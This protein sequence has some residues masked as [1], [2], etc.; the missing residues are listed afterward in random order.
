MDDRSVIIGSEV[1][2]DPSLVLR[3]YPLPTS[4]KSDPYTTLQLITE[5]IAPDS[6]AAVGG[7]G[8]IMAEKHWGGLIV[9]QSPDVQGAIFRFLSDST[10]D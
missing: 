8:Q 9:L 6:W 4:T 3:I 2:D 5:K 10:S 1:G 7:E